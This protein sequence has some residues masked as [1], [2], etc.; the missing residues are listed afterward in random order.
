MEIK[1]RWLVYSLLFIVAAFVIGSLIPASNSGDITP[2]QEKEVL[3]K[4]QIKVLSKDLTKLK[5]KDS[6]LSKMYKMRGDTIKLL[7][8]NTDKIKVVHREAVERTDL[9]P[10]SISLYNEVQISRKLIVAQEAHIQAFTDLQNDADSL[11]KN[12][13]EI[14]ANQEAQL[15]VW[16]ERYANLEAQKD[17]GIKQERKKGN[18]KLFKGMAIGGAVVALL[19]LL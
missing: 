16:P 9:T 4:E 6:V 11:I 8:E 12:Q 18:R 10:D 2:Y 17:E 1:D 3:Y 19:V 7:A 15:M 5:S 14:I 13:R